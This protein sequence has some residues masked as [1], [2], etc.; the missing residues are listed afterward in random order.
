MHALRHQVLLRARAANMMAR[1][2]RRLVAHKKYERDNRKSIHEIFQEQ[3]KA[4]EEEAAL[5]AEMAK[6]NKVMNTAATKGK[7]KGT[8][9]ES[10]EV[11]FRRSLGTENSSSLLLSRYDGVMADDDDV[12][13]LIH[14]HDSIR[15][16]SIPSASEG[17]NKSGGSGTGTGGSGSGSGNDNGVDELGSGWKMVGIGKHAVF[18]KINSQRFSS[19]SHSP[20]HSPSQSPY[21]SLSSTPRD[22]SRGGGMGIKSPPPLSP[23]SLASSLSPS[24][25]FIGTSSHFSPTTSPLISGN[26]KTRL[27]GL[28]QQQHHQQQ[29]QS[30]Q[31]QQTSPNTTHS[32]NTHSSNGNNTHSNKKA[33]SFRSTRLVPLEINTPA[34]PSSSFSSPM[35]SPS[36]LSPLHSTPISLLPSPSGVGVGVGVGLSSS[37][38]SQSYKGNLSSSSSQSYQQTMSISSPQSPSGVM[39]SFL[40]T[41]DNIHMDTPPSQSPISPTRPFNT[42]NLSMHNLTWSPSKRDNNNNN[43]NNDNNNNNQS[44]HHSSNSSQ[45]SLSNKSSL[46]LASSSSKHSGSDRPREGSNSNTTSIR[47]TTITFDSQKLSKFDG[48]LKKENPS[49]STVSMDGVDSVGISKQDSPTKEIPSYPD[50]PSSKKVPP[51]HHTNTTPLLSTFSSSSIDNTVR[52]SRLLPKRRSTMLNREV[53]E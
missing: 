38:P 13:D 46:I 28:Q 8:R 20:T 29:H 17:S 30:E 26:N 42:K 22:T 9:K 52:R 19:P 41:D 16:L 15:K 50:S 3:K 53:R 49:P 2:L 37:S 39:L 33:I 34:S 23:S 47:S 18:V 48:L 43:N 24:P 35:S 32:N 45:P 36:R 27:P 14:S 4:K 51:K 11:S 5:I 1:F 10:N 40:S 21:H 44:E 7:E 6:K 31:L 25:L 12:G